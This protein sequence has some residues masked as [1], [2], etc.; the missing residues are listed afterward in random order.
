MKIG[1]PIKTVTSPKRKVKKYDERRKP[2]PIA[3]PVDIPKK[4]RKKVPEEATAW[5]YIGHYWGISPIM[6]KSV[7]L[8]AVS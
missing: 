1:N 3:I 4:T 7:Y 2:D 6:N 8:T 5:K